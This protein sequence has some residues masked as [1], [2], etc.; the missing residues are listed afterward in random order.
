MVVSCDLDLV[1][2]D[3]KRFAQLATVQY[4]EVAGPWGMDEMRCIAP[5]SLEES[6]ILQK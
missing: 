6:Y 3:A 5:T 4:L 2:S 1:Q